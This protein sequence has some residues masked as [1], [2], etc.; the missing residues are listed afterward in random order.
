MPFGVALATLPLVPTVGGA[1]AYA[2]VGELCGAYP[3]GKSFHNNM[4]CAVMLYAACDFSIRGTSAFDPD[5]VALYLPLFAAA[6]AGAPKGKI[7]KP[8]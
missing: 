7:K 5:K 4:R 3:L 6:I 2:A 1:L 8:Y